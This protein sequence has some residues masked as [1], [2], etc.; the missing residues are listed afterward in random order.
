M[1][2]R[3]EG[4]SLVATSP[5]RGLPDASVMQRSPPSVSLSAT[6]DAKL[7]DRRL[8]RALSA[9]LAMIG[10]QPG[11]RESQYFARFGEQGIRIEGFGHVKIGADLLASLTIEL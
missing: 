4:L 3:E 1:G 2:T 8:T 6:M 11:C 10:L 5:R 7:A 9:M